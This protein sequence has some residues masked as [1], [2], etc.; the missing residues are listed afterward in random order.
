MTEIFMRV[1]VMSATGGTLGLLLILLRPAT[2]KAFGPVW[3]YYIWL[4]TLL[5]F[6]L[7]VS[8][9]TPKTMPKNLPISPPVHTDV[10]LTEFS[11]AKPDN[12]AEEA[13]PEESTPV[14]SAVDIVNILGFVWLFT[15]AALFAVRVM[16]YMIFSRAAFNSSS[17]CDTGYNLP[18]RLLTRKSGVLDSPLLMGVLRPVIYLPNTEITEENMRYILLH[19]LTHYRR[20][21]VLYKWIAMAA[22]CVHWFNP[23]AYMIVRRIDEDCEMSCDY[24]AV[25]QLYTTEHKTYM[26]VILSLLSETVHGSRALTTQMAGSRKLIKRRFTMITNIKKTSRIAA[27][28]SVITAAALMSVTVLASGIISG[29]EQTDN[30]DVTVYRYDEALELE[31]E[32][33]AIDNVMYIP[34]RETLTALGCDNSFITWEQLP[35]RELEYNPVDSD[36]T[37][38]TVKISIPDEYINPE[39]WSETDDPGLTLLRVGIDSHTVCGIPMFGID[40]ILKDGVSYAPCTVF[41]MMKERYNGIADGFSAEWQNRDT[42]SVVR[43][44]TDVHPYTEQRTS[45]LTLEELTVIC[46]NI[47]SFTNWRLS[48]LDKYIPDSESSSDAPLSRRYELTYEYYLTV[49]GSPDVP[50]VWL[51]NQQSGGGINLNIVHFDGSPWWE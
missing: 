11:N 6:L 26:R 48:D 34:I 29:Y 22:L 42:G 3:Q 44:G 9:S 4:S 31:N 41:E 27:A 45:K 24:T 37:V 15:A 28:I 20:K 16:K 10:Q 17:P 13:A 50:E 46:Q 39:A 18:K 2:S 21:D 36:E 35:V 47:G 1:I 49:E 23:L 32:P 25:R 14:F 5:V 51:W 40:T 30:A 12:I 8:F 38:N 7:P 33:F 19:E 43:I